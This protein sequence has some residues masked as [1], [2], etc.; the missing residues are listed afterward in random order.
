MTNIQFRA[1]LASLGLRQVDLARLLAHFDPDWRFDRVT[2]NRWA[3]GQ[4]PRVPASIVMA[5]RLWAEISDSKRQQMLDAAK[6]TAQER[7]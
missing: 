5:L 6:E 7:R 2:V 1:T 3:T 4:V